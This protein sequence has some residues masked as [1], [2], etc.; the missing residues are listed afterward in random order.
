MGMY[1]YQGQL[2][3]TA[4]NYDINVKGVAHRGFSSVAPE[5][6]L[7]AFKLA[8]EK[9]FFYVETDVSFTK[10]YVP[11]CLHDATIDRTSDGT[12]NVNA[13]TWAQLQEYDFGSW[14]SEEYAGTKI[15]S[16]EQFLIF[17]RNAVLHPYIEFKDTATYSEGQIQSVVD[18]VE[19][20]GMAGKVTYISFSA[21]YLGYVKAYD[22][23]A[24]L[25]YL[26]TAVNA[27]VISTAQGLQTTS[28]EV[29]IDSSA[30]GSPVIT[31]CKTAHLP[32]EVWTIDSESTI[33]GLNPYITGVTS[34]SLIAGKVLYE[35][36]MK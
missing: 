22:A 24:R 26:A 10:D 9:G 14:K 12:G 4:T 13:L 23:S 19:A 30:Y 7:P 25:G 11:V 16:L 1:D 5:N 31:L 20:C 36:A 32:L 2:L 15:P 29:F 27:T 34:N 21:T 17:C 3:A 6:T 35:E 8:K 28:N 33:K 18:L